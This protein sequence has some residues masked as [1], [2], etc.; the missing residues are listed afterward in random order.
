MKVL[1]TGGAGFIGSHVADL[2]IKDGHQVIVI[3]DL[4]KGKKENLPENVS[5]YPVSI[6]DPSIAEIFS[7]EKPETVIHHAAQVSVVSSVK[8]PAGDMEINIKGTICL[9]EEAVKHKVE[10]F[11]FASTGGAVYGEQDCFPADENHPLKP[12]SPYGA[13]KLSAEKY[14]YF[15]HKAYGLKYTVLRY[16]NVYGPRQDPHGEAGVVAVFTQKMLNGEEVVI[17][18]TGE[19]TRDFVFVK[20]VAM[21]N[22]MA[23]DHDFNG[24]LN[25]STGTETTINQLFSLLKL[26]IPT[27]I[28]DKHGPALS[29]EQL[30]SVL[31]WERAEKEL[32]WKPRIK[33]REGIEQTVLFF[34]NGV[35]EISS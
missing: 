24:E 5:F 10:K 12:I 32:G 22:R 16:S 2:L 13:G 30:R 6:T 29:G 11:I 33:L 19:Q 34:K 7:D 20:D 21:A 27:S 9:L 17:N 8:D 14:L 18:G 4:S 35:P 25:I 28:S 26:I 31:S 1:I 23:L 3:D 15:Y